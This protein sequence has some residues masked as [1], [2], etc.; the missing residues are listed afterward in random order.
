MVNASSLTVGQR[1]VP[2]VV[3]RRKGSRHLRLRVDYWNRLQISAP[4]HCPE[5]EVQ[6]F[7]EAQRAWITS[8][9]ARAPEPVPLSGWLQRHP[10]VSAGGVSLEVQ[11]ERSERSGYD[12]L[13]GREVVVFR[14]PVG[15]GES[16]LLP[17]FRRFAK[18]V[19]ACRVRHHARA[20]ALE[21]PRLSVRDQ[22]SRWGSCSSRRSLSLNW[23]LVLL[24]PELQDYVIL[25]ELAHLTEMNH[26]AAFWSILE[27]YD[28]RRR[29]HE[30]RLDACSAAI[31][32]VG[33]RRPMA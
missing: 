33:R 23:R 29:A 20:R 25:H 1:R 16:V 18:D 17:L 22:S 21:M 4:W 5:S 24:G 15:S 13:K 9:L 31:M 32:R 12:F 30:K 7:L 28:P 26:S 2:V 10:W 14:W 19:L 6:A 3:T 27:A 11:F 8:Q